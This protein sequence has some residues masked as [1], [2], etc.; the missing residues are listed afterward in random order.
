MKWTPPVHDVLKFNYDGAFTR[1]SHQG[2]WGV[3]A[4]DHRVETVISSA[5]R[6]E[7]ITD[8]F[9]AKLNSIAP[10]VHNPDLSGCY[11]A[12]ILL[13]TVYFI[14]CIK[15]SDNFF[16]KKTLNV[17]RLFL[18][19]PFRVPVNIWHYKVLSNFL[20]GSIAENIKF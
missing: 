1:E 4:R 18:G 16:M 7:C 10:F 9:H 14:P 2:G 20:C 12:R 15:I 17:L 19:S 5:G 11:G 8:S 13:S 6:S 3:I